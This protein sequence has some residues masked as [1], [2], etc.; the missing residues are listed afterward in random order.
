MTDLAIS[1]STQPKILRAAT[2]GRGVFQFVVPQGPAIAVNLQDE[3]EFGTACPGVTAHRSLEIFNVGAAPL[4]VDSIAVLIGSANFSIENQPA[5]PVEIGPGEE[6]TFTITYRPSAPN[7]TDT[8]IVR[9]T[10]NDPRRA[11][12]RRHRVRDRRRARARRLDAGG[13]R[14]GHRLSRTS[15]STAS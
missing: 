9:V 5:T 10:S 8:A 12:R 1:G 3:L 11:G 15:I 13:R 2:Y 4:R 6:L 7:V 14:P